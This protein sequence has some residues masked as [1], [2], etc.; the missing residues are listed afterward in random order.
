MS[1]SSREFPDHP[2][3]GV[4]GILL[5]GERVLLVRR[6]REPL[7][8]QWSIPGGVVEVGEALTDAVVREIREETGLEVRLLGLVEVLDR[9]LRAA[10]GRV[11]Y[12]FVLIDYLCRPAG[13][14]LRASSDAAEVRWV[15]RTELSA[16]AL[17]P[18]TLRVI[19]KAF[20][21]PQ[22]KQP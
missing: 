18:E 2:V 15:E 14:E 10:D 19:E 21:F 3:V 17:H 16:Y 11:Q 8:G 4:G 7:M 22:Q 20:A 1:A 9:I 6:G 12:H 13:G 5:D